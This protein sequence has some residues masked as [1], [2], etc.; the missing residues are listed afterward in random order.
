MNSLT[1]ILKFV[2]DKNLQRMIPWNRRYKRQGSVR[3]SN[4]FSHNLIK[5]IRKILVLLSG[6]QIADMLKGF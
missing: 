1:R 3:S 4:T 6:N 2:R 5:K